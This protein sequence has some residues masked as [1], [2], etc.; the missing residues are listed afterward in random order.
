MHCSCFLTFCT[1]KTIQRF[2]RFMKLC[3]AQL[4]PSISWHDI[5]TIWEYSCFS[6]FNKTKIS[7][8]TFYHI[9]SKWQLNAPFW[10]T[11][12]AVN[13]ICFWNGCFGW[14][15]FR[16]SSLPCVLGCS[17]ILYALKT[18]AW[19]KEKI[20]KWIFSKL[21]KGLTCSQVSIYFSQR[22]LLSRATL[23]HFKS[24]NLMPGLKSVKWIFSLYIQAH[25]HSC[26]SGV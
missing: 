12:T 3:E 19:R 21:S 8:W 17:E 25:I 18:T 16:A 10:Q 6:V 1:L 5:N 24:K 20:T 26:T 23:I 7:Y 15:Y 14:L 2:V 22:R 4:M 9:L 11:L 13:L